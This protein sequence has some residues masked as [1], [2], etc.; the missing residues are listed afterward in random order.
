MRSRFSERFGF[1]KPR[2]AFQIN[3][4]DKALRNRLWNQFR[5]F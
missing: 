1:K 2:D 5:D 3:D 4:I